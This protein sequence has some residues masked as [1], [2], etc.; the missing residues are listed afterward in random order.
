MTPNDHL[1]KAAAAGHANIVQGALADGADINGQSEFD[2]TALHEAAREGHLE[3]VKLL[4]DS[5]ADLTVPDRYK[6]TALQRARAY[7]IACNAAPS[8][9][10]SSYDLER[11]L[12]LKLYAVVKFL[13]EAERKQRHAGSIPGPKASHAKD[14]KKNRASGPRSPRDRITSPLRLR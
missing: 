11:N 8:E 13:E 2:H 12:P 3:V 5:G 4:V 10:L 14:A 7:C 9:T 6:Q 1:I